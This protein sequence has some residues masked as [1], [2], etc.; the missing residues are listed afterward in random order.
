MTGWWVVYRQTDRQT[1][2]NVVARRMPPVDSGRCMCCCSGQQIQ[3]ARSAR[4][5]YV[6]CTMY[7]SASLVLSTFLLSMNDLLRLHCSV[8]FLVVEDRERCKV[9]LSVCSTVQSGLS[10]NQSYSTCVPCRLV[11]LTWLGR[12]DGRSKPPTSTLCY[13]TRYTAPFHSIFR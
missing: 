1:D 10:L 4:T 13:S 8:F 5:M 3:S 2:W 11:R 12:F 6:L 9:C 7:I